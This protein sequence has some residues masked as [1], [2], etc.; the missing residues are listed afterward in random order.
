MIFIVLLFPLALLAM[1]T[2]MDAVED[3]LSP[4]LA[5]TGRRGLAGAARARHAATGAGWT[6]GEDDQDR[7]RPGQGTAPR[8]LSVR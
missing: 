7:W 3:W 4:R 1:T 2:L 8:D 5:P 6:T